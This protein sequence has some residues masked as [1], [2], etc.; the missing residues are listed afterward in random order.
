MKPYR[1]ED[2]GLF[3]DGF[4]FTEVI[5]VSSYVLMLAGI[6]KKIAM[7]DYYIPCQQVGDRFD[8]G[9]FAGKIMIKTIRLGGE[10]YKRELWLKQLLVHRMAYPYM[11]EQIILN[12][13]FDSDGKLDGGTMFK[14]GVPNGH[15]DPSGPLGP[16]GVP[17]INQYP[18]TPCKCHG[19]VFGTVNFIPR[20]GG[21]FI[22][23]LETP[24]SKV[25]RS[26]IQGGYSDHPNFLLRAWKRFWKQYGPY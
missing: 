1:E 11:G 22:D 2:I 7:G 18:L 5:P 25:E 15:I 26:I 10:P 17:G 4:K 8:R 6:E 21:T 24:V 14:D 23:G 9:N 16:S 19:L 13:H 12:P 3:V 20:T